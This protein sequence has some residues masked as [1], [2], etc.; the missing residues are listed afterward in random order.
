MG[1][2]AIDYGRVNF[3]Y[4]GTGVD[5]NV[6]YVESASACDPVKG[7]WYYDVD[8]KGGAMPTQV[9][10]CPA[11]CTKVKSDPAAKVSLTF[12]CKSEVIR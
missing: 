7:R 8:P 6:P 11:A 2:E 3:H 5:E 12:G 9:V 1:T 10:L 4:Q